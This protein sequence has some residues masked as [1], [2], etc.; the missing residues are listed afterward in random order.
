MLSFSRNFIEIY[1]DQV[2][3]VLYIRFAFFLTLSWM[4]MRQLFMFEQLIIK[5][6]SVI[7]RLQRSRF[8][9]LLDKY[10]VYLLSK[11]YCNHYIGSCQRA[12]E[13]CW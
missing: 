11:R 13:H 4:R 3:Y 2:Y 9:P 7:Q 10:A 6:T 12:A 8:K 5:K 1:S